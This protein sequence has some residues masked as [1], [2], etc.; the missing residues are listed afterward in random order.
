MTDEI[1]DLVHLIASKGTTDARAIM[2]GARIRQ[3]E[4]ALSEALD[5]RNAQ[6]GG[7]KTEVLERCREVLEGPCVMINNQT[8]EI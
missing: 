3:L 1:D 8:E 4:A 7:H 6:D 5:W 2:L